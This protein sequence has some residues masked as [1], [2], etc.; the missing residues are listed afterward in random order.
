ME[1]PRV[2]LHDDVSRTRC[3]FDYALATAAREPGVRAEGVAA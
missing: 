3:E 1:L 2:G